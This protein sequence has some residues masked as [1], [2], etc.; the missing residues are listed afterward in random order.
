MK[1]SLPALAVLGAFAS[2]AHAQSSVTL[3]GII[4]EAVVF[5]S[6]AK[7][8]AA[9]ATTAGVGG[10]KFSLDSNTG[11]S[12][13]R[14]G[15]KGAEDLGGGL[16]AIF[17]VESGMNINTGGLNQGGLEFGRQAYVG[18]SSKTYGSIT[19][20]RQYDATPEFIG[21]MIFADQLGGVSSAL[22]GDLNNANNTQRINNAIKYT[23]PSFNGLVFGGLY[24]LGGISGEVA[25]NQIYSFGAGY[26]NGPV[27]L[28]A[29]FLKAK[30]PNTS[31][32]SN[33]ALGSGSLAAG[34]Q[35][36]TTGNNPVYGGY[37]NANSY[38]T[39]AAGGAYAIGPAHFAIVYSNTKFQDLQSGLSGLTT[40][41]TGPQGTAVFNAVE[42]NFVW[43]F[44][45]AFQAG[46]AY[47]YTRA[48]SVQL[49][50]TKTSGGADYNQFT[51]STD[52]AL[53]KRTDVYLEGIYQTASGVDSTGGV[54]VASI[55][56]T[57]PSSNNHEA[58]VRAGVRVK[59]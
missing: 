54:A 16:Q 49:G 40:S 11:L 43:H 4:D 2:L 10:R 23:S 39:A 1:K 48:S 35:S 36:I 20:G 9:T 13:S 21:P 19:L 41:T 46:G 30:Q 52:Y 33:G 55:N 38:Q 7:I 37:V 24:S 32:F 58:L 34:G 25:R 17:N 26:A 14:W 15:L 3:Y 6:N 57:S 44:T 51:L 31:F 42:L 47:S 22:P 59:F 29:A 50:K 53:S 45:P 18:L 8:T 27:T 28:G 5:Q 56:L 12:G